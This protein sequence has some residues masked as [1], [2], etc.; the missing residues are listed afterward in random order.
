M[1]IIQAVAVLTTAAA[2]F[3]AAIGTILNGRQIKI[4]HM[5][6]N[7]RLDQLVA[8]EKARSFSAGVAQERAAEPVATAAQAEANLQTTLAAVSDRSKT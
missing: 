3:A 5:T 7:S 2:A 6:M 1:D 4:V 8:A